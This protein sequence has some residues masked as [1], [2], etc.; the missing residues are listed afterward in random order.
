MRSSGRLIQ[1]SARSFFVSRGLNASPDASL[2]PHGGSAMAAETRQQP[3]NPETKP[4]P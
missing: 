1:G 3:D 2:D 4:W